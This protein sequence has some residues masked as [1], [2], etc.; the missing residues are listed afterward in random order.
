M[1]GSTEKVEMKDKQWYKE[2]N[3]N[4]VGF[5]NKNEGDIQSSIRFYFILC[6]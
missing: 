4:A 6:F 3:N 5:K 2:F 1:G